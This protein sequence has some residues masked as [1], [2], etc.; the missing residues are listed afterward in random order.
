ME[1]NMIFRDIKDANPK[2]FKKATENDIWE[3]TNI[4]IGKL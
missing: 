1:K 2:A 3:K 4:E